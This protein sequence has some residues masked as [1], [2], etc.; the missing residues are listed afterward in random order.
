MKP[1][2]VDSAA[3]KSMLL[4]NL[5]PA[6]LAKQPQ[7]HA[8]SCRARTWTERGFNRRTQ[9]F[10]GASRNY[11]NPRYWFKQRRYHCDRV[12]ARWETPCWIP[13]AYRSINVVQLMKALWFVYVD[14]P[15]KVSSAYK[16][17]RHTGG[18]WPSCLCWRSG[19]QPATE[20][21]DTE[22]RSGVKMK[23]FRMDF[24]PLSS[25]VWLKFSRKYVR[26]S[27]DN[28]S[29]QQWRGGSGM[30]TVVEFYC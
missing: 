11:W 14:L 3:F 6:L 2:S 16:I 7:P 19:F 5:L 20:R 9:R 22:R 12:S 10:I 28:V 17:Q 27:A 13:H 21:V 24:M 30:S 18:K 4:S 15:I 25:C 8:A 29:M 23:I 1:R 26:C